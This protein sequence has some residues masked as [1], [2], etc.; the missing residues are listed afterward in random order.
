M[1]TTRFTLLMVA[2]A[3]LAPLTTS[4]AATAVS[5]KEAREAFV[6]KVVDSKFEKAADS[7]MGQKLTKKMA[8][9]Q[10]F[11]GK[12]GG[13]KV[14]FNDPV[15]KW[16]WFWLLGWAAGVVLYSF[17]WFVAAPFWYL[18]YLCMLG[19]TVCLVIWLLKKSG[20]M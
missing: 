16:M 12:G 10:K 2:F 20:N 15:D 6:K 1:K 18:G 5:A 4:R 9:F 14:D 7:K 3:L 19:G 17:G 11:L 13:K 8:K